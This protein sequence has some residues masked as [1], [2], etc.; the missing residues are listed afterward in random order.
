MAVVHT[1]AE[2]PNHGRIARAITG[3]TRNRSS[4]LEKMVQA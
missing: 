2:P 1:P 3:C 4:A